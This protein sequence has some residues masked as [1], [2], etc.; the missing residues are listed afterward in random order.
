MQLTDRDL[1][2]LGDLTRLHAMTVEQVARRHFGAVNTAANRL[3][4]LVATGCV[5]VE[6]PRFRGRAAYMTTSA[7]ATLTG[8]G[9]AAARFAPSALPHRLAVVDLADALLASHPGASWISERE[10]RRD[11]MMTVRDRRRGQLLSG[12]P[13][14]PDGVLVVPGGLAGGVAVELELSVKRWTEYGRILRWYAGALD[15]RRVRWFCARPATRQRL[16]DLVE[17]ER[18]ADFV[19][20]EALPAGVAVTGWG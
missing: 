6:R 2:I 16:A 12:T 13:H 10:L 3:A 18:M 20:V 9:L 5:R 11:G 17:R 19:E 15:Y 14:A 4:Q 7:G 1:A 8:A